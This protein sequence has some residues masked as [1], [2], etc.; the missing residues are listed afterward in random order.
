MGWLK[1]SDIR[2]SYLVH[3]YPFLARNSMPSI[4]K[5]RLLRAKEIGGVNTNDKDLVVTS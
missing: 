1:C 3:Q 2:I 5:R 4:P